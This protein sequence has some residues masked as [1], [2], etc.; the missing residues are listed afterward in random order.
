MCWYLT[1]T[2]T[3]YDVEGTKSFIK[4]K[5]KQVVFL[6]VL[7]FRSM[8]IYSF[9]CTSVSTWNYYKIEWPS[10][11]MKKIFHEK[12]KSAIYGQAFQ[13]SLIIGSQ[14][15]ASHLTKCTLAI[16]CKGLFVNKAFT[17]NAMHC[18]TWFWFTVFINL[19]S[20]HNMFSFS[21]HD[22]CQFFYGNIL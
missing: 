4:Q 10:W 18:R 2:H 12:K 7:K 1:L 8:R 20:F 15:W 11:L 21:R 14:C 22:I 19:G 3:G 16:E 17:A 5:F 6:R 13:C 9:F